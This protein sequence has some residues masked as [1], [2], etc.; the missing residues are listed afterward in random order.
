VTTSAAS[1]GRSNETKWFSIGV[2]EMTLSV[3]NPSGPEGSPVRASTTWIEPRSSM[4]A[5]R[6]APGASCHA[7]L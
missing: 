4:K 7:L 1:P 5:I 2:T 6:L 3:P